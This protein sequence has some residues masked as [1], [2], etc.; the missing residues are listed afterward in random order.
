MTPPI[1]PDSSDLHLRV[2]IPWRTTQ[3][4]RA[5][6]RQKLDYYF[7]CVRRA[8]AEPVTISLEQSPAQLA[9]QLNQLDAFVLPGS[10]TDVDPARYGAA[11]H[12]KADESDA[13]RD[14]TDAAIL[15]HAFAHLNPVLAIC[16]GCQALNV[17][18]GGTLIQ[19]IPSER[20]GALVH[21]KTDL[22]ATANSGDL[23]HEVQLVPGSRLASLN[24][25][26]HAIINTSHHQAI[27][28]PGK[29]LRVTAQAPDGIIEGVEWQ[30]DSPWA[31]GV[32]WH[33]E[34]MAGDRFSE[35]LFE[36]FVAAVR[37]ARG[38]IAHTR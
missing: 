34:R 9:E 33:P 29:N 24:C 20:P 28:Q 2:G 18:L 36:D 30:G 11:K 16:Y 10:P 7:A 37:S 3:E 23:E 26:D 22:A 35:R 17:F 5:G 14:A 1:T 12:P 6:T 15:K 25:S 8:E 38:A 32:Q 27:D 13:Q 31:V 19:D 4:E 21:G